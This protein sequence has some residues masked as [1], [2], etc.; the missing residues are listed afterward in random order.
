MTDDNTDNPWAPPVPVEEETQ[1][2]FLNIVARRCWLCVS[3]LSTIPLM[4][5]V[6]TLF[7]HAVIGG[8]FEIRNNHNNVLLCLTLASS[9]IGVY[10]SIPAFIISFWLQRKLFFA[11]LSLMWSNILLFIITYEMVMKLNPL[12]LYN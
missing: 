6:V 10:T 7:F 12:L 3:F 1:K 8:Y 4:L 11:S 9:G 2:S 5:A